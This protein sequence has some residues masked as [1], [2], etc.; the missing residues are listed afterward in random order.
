MSILDS[1]FYQK[2]LEIRKNKQLDRDYFI[3]IKN[4]KD[5]LDNFKLINDSFFLSVYKKNFNDILD[6][7][8]KNNFKYSK[9]DILSIENKIKKLA[10]T[11][12]KKYSKMLDYMTLKIT[13]IDHE[14]PIYGTLINFILAVFSDINYTIN[15]SVKVN[16]MYE[17]KY[18]NQFSTFKDFEKSFLFDKAVKETI[19]A[20]KFNENDF[21]DLKN[22]EDVLDFLIIT[23]EGSDF[24]LD[25]FDYKNDDF[26]YFLFEG[27]KDLYKKYGEKILFDIKNNIV[28]YN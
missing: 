3:K 27:K 2:I 6:F 1:D 23:S 28:S 17:E 20:F 5:Q 13:D 9:Y 14:D 15:L 16:K 11:D 26:S 7:E 22:I 12:I 25:D 24:Y 19:S 18:S 8:I 4:L 10:T 21:F